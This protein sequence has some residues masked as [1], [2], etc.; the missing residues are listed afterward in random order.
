MSERRCGRTWCTDENPCLR[1][2]K[3]KPQE[4]TPSARATQVDQASGVPSCDFSGLPKHKCSHCGGRWD[5]PGATGDSPELAAIRQ[6]VKGLR[7]CDPP[8]AQMGNILL[9]MV[10]E[11]TED[12][13]ILCMNLDALDAA[14][15]SNKDWSRNDATVLVGRENLPREA[16]APDTSAE[17]SAGSKLPDQGVAMVSPTPLEVTFSRFQ[18]GLIGRLITE[19]DDL[20]AKLA[21]AARIHVESEAKHAYR[22]KELEAKLT[23]SEASQDAYI[24][25]LE[26]MRAKLAEAE[27]M[28]QH[29]VEEL[30]G[31]SAKFWDELRRAE[32]AEAR[33][34]ELEAY[35]QRLET[36]EKA[37]DARVEELE[38]ERANCDGSY[39]CL[40][41]LCKKRKQR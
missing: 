16:A 34:R 36:H 1:C 33:V 22:V 2:E 7:D 10:D 35:V 39:D 19:R 4:G 26:Q 5:A 38:Y 18:A 3:A 31:E 21:E 17:V 9:G 24:V 37:A 6:Q 11:L 8:M 29:K 32:A 40:C 30:R 27:K 23:V 14:N 15:R 20:R 12:K 13:R 28:V 41:D 25:E